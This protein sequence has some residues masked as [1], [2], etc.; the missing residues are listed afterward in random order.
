MSEPRAASPSDAE[1]RQ[2]KTVGGTMKIHAL[3]LSAS[4]LSLAWCDLASAQTAPTPPPSTAQNPPGAASTGNSSTNA[5][6]EVVVTGERRTTNLQ[7]TPIA[8]TVL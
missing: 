3:W 4:V 6:K 1:E 7:T 2:S 8:A 5:V